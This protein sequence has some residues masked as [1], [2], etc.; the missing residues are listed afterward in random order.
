M[1]LIVLILISLTF[2]GC[3]NST[4]SSSIRESENE[5]NL[6]LND[7]L[8]IILSD[9]IKFL[10]SIDLGERPNSVAVWINVNEDTIVQFFGYKYFVGIDDPSQDFVWQTN[11]KNVKLIISDNK[12]KSS[13]SQ[14]CNIDKLHPF[15]NEIPDELKY[16]TF[17]EPSIEGIRWTYKY[18]DKSLVKTY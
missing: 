18:S 15:K 13:I 14:F 2:F 5:E 9:Y 4:N 7:D 12:E 8:N 11:L 6:F 3:Y 10:E 1:K 17:H 16:R